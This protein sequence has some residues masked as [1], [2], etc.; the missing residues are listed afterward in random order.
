MAKNKDFYK[1]RGIY[2]EYIEY[3]LIMDS[4]VCRTASPLPM[5]SVHVYSKII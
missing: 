5:P 1:V 2:K 4:A 3:A